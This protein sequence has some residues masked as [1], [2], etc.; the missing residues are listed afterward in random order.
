MNVGL[1]ILFTALLGAE[2]IRTCNLRSTSWIVGYENR[3]QAVFK[4]QFNTLSE[5]DVRES[6]VHE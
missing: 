2:L 4:T 6:I 5:C 3:R 1:R